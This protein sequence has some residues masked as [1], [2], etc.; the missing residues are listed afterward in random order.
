MTTTNLINV[1]YLNDNSLIGIIAELG[2]GVLVQ[3][4]R[5]GEN[6]VETIHGDRYRLHTYLNCTDFALRMSHD[7]GRLFID[8]SINRH[9]MLPVNG[10]IIFEVDADTFFRLNSPGN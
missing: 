8:A 6:L 5:T 10:Q 2:L 9:I 7:I 4:V 3:F 1:F